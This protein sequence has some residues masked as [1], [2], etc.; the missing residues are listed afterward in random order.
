MT[1]GMPSV[2][3]LHDD[4]DGLVVHRPTIA[5]RIAARVRTFSLD[6]QLARGVPPESDV[7]LAVRACDLVQPATRDHLARSLERL[8]Q[9]ASA[10]WSPFHPQ[11]LMT[12]NAR[13]LIRESEADLTMV[14]QQLRRQ[15]PISCR[16]VAQLCVV[17]HDGSGPLYAPHSARELGECL[18][19]LCDLLQPL[20]D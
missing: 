2:V 10:A 11:P 16:G 17:L 19:H 13:R 18:H 15:A 7:H 14:V 8:A 12:P 3:V 20:A 4:V 1:M 9:A 5:E 6:E